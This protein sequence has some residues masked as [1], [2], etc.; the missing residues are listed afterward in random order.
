MNHHYSLLIQ[1]SEEDQLYLV[2]IPE[3]VGLIKQPCTHGK[4]Y[5]EAIEMAQDCIEVCLDYFE[6]Q[7]ITPPV[8]QVLEVA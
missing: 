8:P 7:S 3:F 1:W 6:Q 2:T 5:E 4:T